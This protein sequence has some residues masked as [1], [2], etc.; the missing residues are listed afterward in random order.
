[1]HMGN[2]FNKITPGRVRGLRQSK[3]VLFVLIEA[4]ATKQPGRL[5]SPFLYRGKNRD[6]AATGF[7]S[8]ARVIPPSSIFF[9]PYLC[10]SFCFASNVINHTPWQKIRHQEQQWSS[11]EPRLRRWAI[12]QTRSLTVFTDGVPIHVTHIRGKRGAISSAGV[13]KD[14]GL[15]PA[16]LAAVNG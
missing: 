1:M 8:H 10:V 6:D 3:V 2:A 7:M 4:R 16:H 15:K 12:A 9:T 11:M 5:S 14:G 13:G